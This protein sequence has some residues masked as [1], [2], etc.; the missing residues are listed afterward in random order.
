MLGAGICGP[1]RGRAARRVLSV[2]LWRSPWRRPPPGLAIRSC[3]C[4]D[5]HRGLQCTARTVVQ[6]TDDLDVRRRRARRRRRP[7]RRRARASSCTSRARPSTAT[8]DRAGLLRLAGLLP[9][10]ERR[11]SATPARSRRRS[12]STATTSRSSRRSRRC[13]GCRR[14]AADRACA[15]RRGC[16]APRGRCSRRSM[17]SGL[18]PSLGR[19]VERSARAHGRAVVAAPAGPLG[20]FPP[21]PLVPGASIAVSLASGRPVRRRRRHRDLSRRRRRLRLRPSARRAPGAA[22]LLLQDA[23]VFTVVGNPLDFGTGLP[24]S[25][26]LAAPGH[27]L[28]T[29]S[30]R[31]S[32]GRRRARSGALPRDDPAHASRVRDL[33]RGTTSRQRI[34]ARRRDR[35]RDAR[36]ARPAADDR[37]GSRSRQARRS[38]ALDGAPAERERAPVPARPRA[39]AARPA[40]LLQPLRRRRARRREDLPP[41]SRCR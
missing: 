4:S 9:R 3:R 17:I 28:G 12:A 29:L 41:R 30:E 14:R 23:Y 38:I 35:R 27:A 37:V 22:A 16:C 6:G 2:A 40:A 15:A 1:T 36:R 10:R 26:K 13:S 31:P 5:I 39:R 33:D 8:G 21:Q 24:T 32:A 7:R 19:L 25:Y 34:A 11:R 18:S 20:T